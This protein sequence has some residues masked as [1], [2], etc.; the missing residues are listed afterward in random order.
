MNLLLSRRD[1]QQRRWDVVVEVNRIEAGRGRLLAQITGQDEK[2]KQ[3][4]QQELAGELV[5]R[6]EQRVRL[7]GGGRHRAEKP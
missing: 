7:P 3:R 6:P 5:Q 1:E 4:E 2:T